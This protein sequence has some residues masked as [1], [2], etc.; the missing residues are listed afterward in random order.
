MANNAIY[1]QIIAVYFHY[2]DFNGIELYSPT[3]NC[4]NT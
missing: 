2:T 4:F 3:F 1:E